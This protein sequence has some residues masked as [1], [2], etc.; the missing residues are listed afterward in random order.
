MRGRGG[1]KEEGRRRRGGGGEEEGR[2]EEGSDG[3]LGRGGKGVEK[4]DKR[5][6][7]KLTAA[8]RNHRSS[9]DETDTILEVMDTHGHENS[10]KLIRRLNKMEEIRNMK[11]I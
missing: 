5:F 9:F 1:E 2:R 11:E 6:K 7:E 8:Q 10:C 3:R 4:E